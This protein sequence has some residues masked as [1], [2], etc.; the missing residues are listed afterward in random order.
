MR[1]AIEVR[2]QGIEYQSRAI[3]GPEYIVAS[4]IPGMNRFWEPSCWAEEV[5]GKDGHH[6]S[7]FVVEEVPAGVERSLDD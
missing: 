7:D 1:E 4:V 5:G 2:Q 6:C 3:S